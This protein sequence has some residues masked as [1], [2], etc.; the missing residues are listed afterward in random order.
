MNEADPLYSSFIINCVFNAF[1]AYTAIMLNILTI[2]AV[3]KTLSLPKPL[4]TLL[5]S[6]AV[7][8]LGVGL[9]A[10]PLYI[11][12]MIRPTASS[13]DTALNIIGLTFFIA[14]FLTVVALTVDR[15]LAIHLHLRYQ[16]LVTHKRANAAAISIWVQSVILPLF[17]LLSSLAK[18]LINIVVGLCFIITAV[19]NCRIYCAVRHHKNQIQVLQMQVAGNSQVEN[20]ARQRK[21]AV[22]TI[23][24]YLVFLT[25]CLPK[26]CATVALKIYPSS[27]A[28]NALRFYTGTL[29]FLNSSLNPVIYCWRM[30]PIR[31]AIKDV[32]QKVYFLLK[33]EQNCEN[34]KTLME[35]I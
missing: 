26:F 22:G 6:L 12:L 1:T 24:V 10:Q 19:A 34:R 13:T 7:S 29:L 21:S 32:L 33:S 8:D 30:R 15:F 20:A 3:R 16:E 17:C 5:L 28:V 23:C 27:V 2:H 35:Q 4:K 31:H 14:S 9:L 18:G 11:A 25:C